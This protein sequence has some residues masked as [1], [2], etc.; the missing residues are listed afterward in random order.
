MDP[1]TLAWSAYQE[2]IREIE[3]INGATAVLSWDQQTHMPPGGSGH[4]GQQLAALAA[5]SHERMTAPELGELLEVLLGSSDPMR[6]A[7]A[8]RVKRN[9][10]RATRVPTDLVKAMSKARSD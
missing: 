6:V 2:R 3:A 4:R 8:R 10:D 7:A 5:L 1:D 9:H